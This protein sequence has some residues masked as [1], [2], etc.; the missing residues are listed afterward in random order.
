MRNLADVLVQ[1]S[2]AIRAG[3]YRY[4]LKSGG[5]FGHQY[6]LQGLVGSSLSAPGIW[7]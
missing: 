1:I 2:N 5:E 7:R 4:S 6:F 3:G